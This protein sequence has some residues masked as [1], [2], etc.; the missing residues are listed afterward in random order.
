VLEFSSEG[1]FGV[2]FILL[3][4]VYWIWFTSSAYF[5]SKEAIFPKIVKT[6]PNPTA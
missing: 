3:F 2:S 1:E 6:F 5:F 4:F